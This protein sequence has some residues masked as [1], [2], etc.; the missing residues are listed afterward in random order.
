MPHTPFIVA[1]FLITTAVL[2]WSALAPVVSQRKL[3][4]QLRARQKHMEKRQ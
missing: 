1:A 4:R 2:L 3:V